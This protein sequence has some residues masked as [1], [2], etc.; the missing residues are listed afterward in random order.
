MSGDVVVYKVNH[1]PSH[2]GLIVTVNQLG[3]MRDIM[4]ISKWGKLAEFL[5]HAENVPEFLGKPIEFYTDRRFHEHVN[6]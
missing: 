6:T 3:T 2:V 4:V 5:H 1:E